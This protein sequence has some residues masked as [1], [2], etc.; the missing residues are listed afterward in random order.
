MKNLVT[1]VTFGLLIFS[2]QVGGECDRIDENGS[3]CYK[4]DEASSN[5]DKVCARLKNVKDHTTNDT[6]VTYF[7]GISESCPFNIIEYN[8]GNTLKNKLDYE[9]KKCG[10][11]RHCSLLVIKK[12]YEG[13]FDFNF[14]DG[15]KTSVL[16][17][18]QNEHTTTINGTVSKT[19]INPMPKEVDLILNPGT[20]FYHAV[21]L[22]CAVNNSSTFLPF[23]DDGETKVNCK[24]FNFALNIS[25]S[26]ED[27]KNEDFIQLT[28]KLD[29]ACNNMYYGNT[30]LKIN[31]KINDRDQI[32][33]NET[34]KTDVKIHRSLLNMNP[35]L[36]SVPLTSSFWTSSKIHKCLNLHP[37]SVHS[38]SSGVFAT[39][40]QSKDIIDLK[41]NE[42]LKQDRQVTVQCHPDIKWYLVITIRVVDHVRLSS[43]SIG[44][45]AS[46][47]FAMCVCLIWFLKSKGYIQINAQ[48]KY[49]Y[50]EIVARS[51]IVVNRTESESDADEEL[52]RSKD[53]N[54][55]L[56]E[57]AFGNRLH[58]VLK[59]FKCVKMDGFLGK[60]HFGKVHHG[61]LNI[62]EYTKVEVAI[63]EAFSLEGKTDLIHE[64]KTLDRVKRNDYI[65]NLQGITYN[66]NHVYLLLEY[67]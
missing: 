13:Q 15:N 2:N 47:V 22:G 8:T 11:C 57:K 1:F 33:H 41:F 18:W 65:V 54:R 23:Y 5:G 24:S 35:R 52:E 9:V 58:K 67:W 6:T 44:L 17:Y 4:L 39:F 46:V 64:A 28:K 12:S 3:Q 62:G 45:M 20:K 7:L 37:N 40:D 34:F 50:N 14:S 31:L 30:V 51:T 26:M 32:N 16:L 25:K 59:P 29:Y 21:Q 56:L 55:L 43:I 63:K 19:L 60:G 38:T 66:T 61:F 53:E 10:A 42:T 48:P 36:I 49:N 27:H